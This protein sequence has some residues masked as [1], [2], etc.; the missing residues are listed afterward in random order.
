MPSDLKGLAEGE[1]Y[2]FRIGANADYESDYNKFFLEADDMGE[3][4]ALAKLGFI[5]VDSALPNGW[6]YKAGSFIEAQNASFTLNGVPITRTTNKID[7]LIA[8]VTLEIVGPGKV[9]MNV[10]QDAKTAVEGIEAFV[11]AY[12]KVMT[13][14]NMRVADRKSVV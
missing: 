2:I 3:N 13:V 9:T 1:N 6:E 7:D 5:T 4:S 8:D 10:T 11:E 14:I 12:N